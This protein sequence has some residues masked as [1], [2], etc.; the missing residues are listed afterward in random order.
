MNFWKKLF[1]AKPKLAVPVVEA[2]VPVVNTTLPL[3]FSGQPL[4]I[5][6]GITPRPIAEASRAAP[7]ATRSSALR[8][9]AKQREDIT[10]PDNTESMCPHK[11]GWDGES[12]TCEKCGMTRDQGHN[13]MYDP[14]KCHWCGKVRQAPPEEMLLFAIRNHKTEEAEG[15]ISAGVKFPPDSLHQTIRLGRDEAGLPIVEMLVKAGADINAR[16]G[17]DGWTPLMGAAYNEC[18]RITDYLIQNGADTKIRDKKGRTVFSLIEQENNYRHHAVRCVLVKATED[19]KAWLQTSTGQAWVKAY[20]VDTTAPLPATPAEITNLLRKALQCDGS[21]EL[22]QVVRWV[23]AGGNLE[24]KTGNGWTLLHLAAQCGNEKMVRFFLERGAQIDSR[25][26][27]NETPLMLACNTEWRALKMNPAVVS[28]LLERGADPNAENSRGIPPLGRLM[29]AD[30]DAAREISALLVKYG[31]RQIPGKSSVCQECGAPA[32]RSMMD[33]DVD[34]TLNG[35]FANFNCPK[36][37][38]R[39]RAPL[40]AITKDKGVRVV[41]SSCQAIAYIPPW[42]WCNTCGRGLSSGWQQQIAAKT[43]M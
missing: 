40:E 25:D 31:A 35:V 37:Q 32:S 39:E 17:I 20:Q 21:E 42:V 12:C 43:R 38:S 30:S 24:W 27:R 19:G 28:F 5:K 29:F 23:D 9:S 7:V 4:E 6:A 34:V 2:T 22:Q 33:R 15:L 36:C 41:C 11:W 14:C 8:P 13:W 1:G 18:P 16:T 10:K 3:Q 26:E